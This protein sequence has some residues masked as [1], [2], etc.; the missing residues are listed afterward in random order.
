MTINE[1]ADALALEIADLTVIEVCRYINALRSD[2]SDRMIDFGYTEASLT[3]GEG[4]NIVE[5]EIADNIKVLG[6]MFGSYSLLQTTFSDSFN[7]KL[8]NRGLPYYYI[9]G[10]TIRVTTNTDITIKL[11]TAP[12]IPEISEPFKATVETYIPTYMKEYVCYKIGSVIASK[13]GDWS[14]QG[15]YKNQAEKEVIRIKKDR[16]PRYSINRGGLL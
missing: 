5:Y 3:L 6:V 7:I 4:N 15:Y 9:E 12:V 1:I 8:D 2:I 16:T 14:R 13:A 10:N 11:R